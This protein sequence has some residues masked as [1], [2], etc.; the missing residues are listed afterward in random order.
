MSVPIPDNYMDLLDRPIVSAV[1]TVMPDGQP[2]ATPVWFDYV[3]GYFRFNTAEG[4]QKAKNLARDSRVTFL[5]IDPQNSFHW[6]EVRGRVEEVVREADG[7][8]EAR[9]H[10]NTLSKKYTGSAV[11][12]GPASEGRIMYKITAE[13]INTGR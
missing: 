5:I 12:G 2:Q 10:I 6:M 3:D 1:V 11:Y 13:K 7:M 8:P 9:E 4:R